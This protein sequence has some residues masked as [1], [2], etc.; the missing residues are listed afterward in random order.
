MRAKPEE[1]AQRLLYVFDVAH[2]AMKHVAA[3]LGVTKMTVDH[4]VQ[5]LGLSWDLRRLCEMRGYYA[6][7]S[8]SFPFRK[9]YLPIPKTPPPPIREKA[10]RYRMPIRFDDFDPALADESGID[11]WLDYP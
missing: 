5:K 6:H 11:G 2:G 8:D 1:A 9:Y 4:W 10:K 7:Y 3:I